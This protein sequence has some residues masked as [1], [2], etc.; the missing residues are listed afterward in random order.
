MYAPIIL[1]TYNRL[2]HLNICLRS[3][4]KN[5]L[6]KESNLYI[7]SDGSKN[8]KDEIKVKK[9]R[10]HL[11]SLSGF[12][13][14]T[15]IERNTNF[16]LAKNI[17]NGLNH[18]F[19][20]Y[21]KAII[22]EDDLLLSPFFLEFMNNNLN[23][24]EDS[25]KVASI[26]GYSYPVTNK[27]NKDFFIRGADCWGWATWSNAWKNFNEDGSYLLKEIREQNLIRDF[28]YNNK[29][30]FSKMLNNQ[31]NGIIDSWAIRW[32]ASI[33]LKD[34]LTLYPNKSYVYNIGNDNSGTN[35][36]STEIFDVPINIEKPKNYVIEEIENIQMRKEFENYFTLLHKQENFI[37]KIIKKISKITPEILK[38]YLRNYKAG[39]V[40]WCS[41][42]YKNWKD[43]CKESRGY[44]Q[45]NIL[46][47]VYNSSK[48]VKLGLMPYERDS[49]LFKEVKY[50]DNVVEILNKINL[51]ES[52]LSILDFG[53]ALG[54]S[55]FQNKDILNNRFNLKWGIVE[56]ENYV[57]LGLAEFSDDKLSFFYNISD[58]IKTLAPNVALFGSSIQYLNEPYEI[59]DEITNSD[60]I[61]Y[62][63]F[64]RTPFEFNKDDTIVVQN[65]PKKIYEAN[66]P[67]RIFSIDKFINKLSSNWTVVKIVDDLHDD[68]IYY[69][70]CRIEHKCI[71]LKKII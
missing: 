32:H 64:D 71:I 33:Y 29:A 51:S 13:K 20:K 16:G 5:D 43:A 63:I 45:K 67:M 36:L 62:L 70:K 26:H 58:C 2:D 6:A 38:K 61:K 10:K 60:D 4:I 65:V 15:I 7:F 53:G 41:G 14:I 68:V 24:Y 42:P 12:K 37:T 59:I 22:I 19:S 35:A 23:I 18:I 27:K 30:K 46:D 44:D 1:F 52:K 9:I 57:K 49:V 11:S 69:K 17:I 56:Q 31:I 50:N 39:E 28:D 3:L 54:S 66:Y 34:M 55:Y 25:E 47:K 40:N 48:L 8:S 21:K